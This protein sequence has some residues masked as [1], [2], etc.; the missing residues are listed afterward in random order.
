MEASVFK[1]VLMAN[2]ERQVGIY[3]RSTT[4]SSLLFSVFTL[5]VTV[6]RYL[7][8]K[9][10]ADLRI[11][12]GLLMSWSDKYLGQQAVRVLYWGNR[13]RDWERRMGQDRNALCS[14]ANLA[15]CET[16][17]QRNCAG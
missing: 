10:D 14:S 8:F 13:S 5:Q 6:S 2:V 4:S 1:P 15:S 11:N 16:T 7:Q 12:K 17:A 3:Y 9:G